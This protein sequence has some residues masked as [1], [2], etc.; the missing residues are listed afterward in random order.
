MAQSEDVDDRVNAVWELTNNFAI[1]EDKDQAWD[2][3]H[4][5]TR[6]KNDYVRQRAAFALGSAYFYIP[7]KHKNHAWDDLHWL[8]Q[9]A[10]SRVRYGVA[11]AMSDIFAKVPDKNQ[12][13]DDLM[14]L[15]HDMDGKVRSKASEALFS[16]FASLPDKNQ[17]WEKLHQLT[18]NENKYVRMNAAYVLGA[19]LASVPNK[20]L[21]WEDIIRLAQDEDYHVRWNATYA[22]SVAFAHTSNKK[23]AWENLHLL[24]QNTY[25]DVRWRVAASLGKSFANIP[26]KNQ[27]WDDL[28]QLTQDV[29]IR[30][31]VNANYSLGSAS[32]F[33]ATEMENEWDFRKELEKAMEFFE[34][35]SK[36]VNVFTDNFARFCL[37]FYR[38]FYTITFKKQEAGDEVQEYLAE[39]KNA[40]KGSESKE[41]LLEAVE[42]LASA[43]KEAQN[44][45]EFSE[46]KS[47]LNAYRRY[48]E[49]AADLLGTAEEK[50]PGATR[51]IKRGLPIIDER[52]KGIISEIQ[53][54]S[55]ALCKQTKGT[56]LGDLGKEVSRQ[57]QSLLQIGDSIKLEKSV[58]NFLFALSAICAKMPRKDR[59]EACELIKMAYKER[60]VEDILNLINMALPKISSQLTYAEEIEEVHK[61]LNKIEIKINKIETS[62]DRIIHDLEK[63]GVK[64]KDEDKE[65]LKTLASDL[66]KANQEQL[67]NIK[68]K[69]DELKKW[70]EDSKRQEDIEKVPEKDKPKI[71]NIFSRIIGELGIALTS[72]IT[73]E[74]LLPRIE[75]IMSEIKIL[76]GINPALAS[77]LILLLI[78]IKKSLK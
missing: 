7:E 40:V 10:E 54:K 76:S 22:L 59:G 9:D 63:G 35:S 12:A 48:L 67:E 31:R 32:I 29:D 46:M 73:A 26:D 36:E 5:F 11:G 64:L 8:M 75:A 6:D 60:Y 33:N 23:Q 58:N 14:L 55:K 52:I 69:L 45:R 49:R 71:K 24:V 34:K 61:N 47:D 19:Y 68:N 18:R 3:L 37:P 66:R 28:H 16:A 4:K 74:A 77:T 50:A 15:V 2:D 30:V 27:A 78:T 42:N 56:S 72:A 38:S 51:L 44:A 41:K 43:L 57:G 1:L 25:S 53:E 39:A 62:C 65:E 17:A 20:K 21:V 13:W 70:L